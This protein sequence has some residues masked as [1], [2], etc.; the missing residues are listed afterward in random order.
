[1]KIISIIGARPQ[2]IKCAPLSRAIRK[3]CQEI[4][5][6]TGQHYDPKL[7]NIFF[8]ELN[9]PKPDYNLNIGSAPHGEQTG[10]MLIEIEKILIKEQPDLVLTYGDTNS[11]LAGALTASKLHIKTAHVEAGLRSFDRT[12]PEEINRILTDNISDLLFCPTETALKNLISEGITK[13]VYLVGDVMKD[14]LEYN[15]TIAEEQSEILSD[16]DLISG[17]FIVATLHRPAN[18]DSKEKL[19]S[20]LKAFYNVDETIV[21]PVHPRTEKYLQEYSQWDKLCECVKV[22][23][24]LGYIDM[25]KLMANAKKILTDSGGIQKEAYMLGVPCITM[26]ENTEWVETIEEGWN[27]LVGS[28]YKKIVD[29]IKGFEGANKRSDVFGRGNSSERIVEIIRLTPQVAVA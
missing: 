6:H 27:M 9:I 22:I 28:D 21:F 20:V 3:Q 15:I 19:L 14:A 12:M 4:L 17:E 7:S 25:L 18:T 2:F 29:A 13:G 5:L 26:R 11:T 16:L 23:Q 1:M 8:N 10:K 24:P